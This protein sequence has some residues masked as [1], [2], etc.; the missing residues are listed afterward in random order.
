MKKTTYSL[1]AN[2]KASNGKF[3]ILPSDGSLINIDKS[4]DAEARNAAVD[5]LMKVYNL[6]GIAEYMRIDLRAQDFEGLGNG[7][8]RPLPIRRIPIEEILNH[9]IENL[10]D[11]AS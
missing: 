8:F 7:K 2:Y 1:T 9:K 6:G 11:K 5:Y 3:G 10:E 4:N